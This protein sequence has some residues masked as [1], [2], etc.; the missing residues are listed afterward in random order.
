MVVTSL[1]LG[2]K[3]LGFKN[4]EETKFLSATAV[5]TLIAGCAV[6]LKLPNAS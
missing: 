5:T 4:G 6:G 2:C 3:G 1:Y